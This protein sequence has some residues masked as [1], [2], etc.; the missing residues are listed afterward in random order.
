M[1]FGSNTSHRIRTVLD[2]YSIGCYSP[3][4]KFLLFL[5][6]LSALII[7]IIFAYSRFE[8]F[9][10]ELWNILKFIGWFLLAHFIYENFVVNLITG[11]LIRRKQDKA[12]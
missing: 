11:I 12:Q 9:E 6:K 10:F 4:G 8:G 3:I 1:F 2:L 5:L 7:P